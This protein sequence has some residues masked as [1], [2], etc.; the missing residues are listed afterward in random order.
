MTLF[1]FILGIIVI[2]AVSRY[3]ESDNL[4]WKL[5]ISLMGAFTAVSVVDEIT[6]HKKQDKVVV[7]EKAP[8]QVLESVSYTPAYT[9]TDMSIAATKLEK[10][11]KPVGKDSL[12]D[13][14]DSILSEVFGGIR[15]QPQMCKYFDDS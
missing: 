9:V 14:N 6:S 10:S 12:I 13:R 7:I 11:T 1:G 8:T 4:F 2:I 3:C 5:L 15:G